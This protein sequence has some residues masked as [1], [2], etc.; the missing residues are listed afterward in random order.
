[1]VA[2]GD[3]SG[4]GASFLFGSCLNRIPASDIEVIQISSKLPSA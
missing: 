4:T 1:M 2:G 3:G